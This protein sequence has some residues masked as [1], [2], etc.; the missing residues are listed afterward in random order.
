MP[1]DHACCEP[2]EPL[3]SGRKKPILW[4]EVG[5]EPA[6]LDLSAVGQSRKR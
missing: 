1:F 2:L 5:V 4:A 6:E 3:R